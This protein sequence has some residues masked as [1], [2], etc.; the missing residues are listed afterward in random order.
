M[1]LDKFKSLITAFIVISNL[2]IVNAQDLSYNEIKSHSENVISNN[3][4]NQIVYVCSGQYAYAYHSNDKCPGL[5]NCGGQILTTNEDAA[6]SSRWNKPCCRCWSNVKSNCKDDNPTY[7]NAYGGGGGNE[8]AA[9][10]AAIAIIAGSAIVLSNDLYVYR[11]NSFYNNNINKILNTTQIG[12]STGWSFGFRKTFNKSALEYGM[13]I[14]QTEIKYNKN[15]SNTSEEY[16]FNLNYIH[17]LFDSKL[18]ENFKI[19]LGPTI[20][21]SDVFD[22]IG[23]GGIIGTN[24]KIFNRLKIDLRYEVTNQTNQIQLGLIFNY[25]KKYFWQ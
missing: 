20:N 22:N 17:N 24:Y 5:N 6:L 10:A 12:N 18:T 9:S 3:E 15:F 19:Y 25:Q 7:G 21:T 1:S 11:I 13:S 23:Y 2:L 16:K 8:D 4:I 14:F